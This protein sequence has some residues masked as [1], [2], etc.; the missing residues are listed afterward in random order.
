MAVDSTILP[1]GETFR[2]SGGEPPE[3]YTVESP[4]GIEP[5]DSTARVILRYEENHISAGV[6]YSGS[7]YRVV[8][9][10]FPFEAILGEEA[11]VMVMGRVLEALK[12]GE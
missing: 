11:R 3:I 12:P 9:F 6:A 2:Y 10:G 5:A 8:L 1:R 7:D 4:D